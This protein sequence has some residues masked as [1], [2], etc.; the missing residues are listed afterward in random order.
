MKLRNKNT[1]EIGI[2]DAEEIEEKR[3]CIRSLKTGRVYVY[4]SLAK[5]NE[6]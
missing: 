6:E 5:L 3:F 1:G 2:N 4:G